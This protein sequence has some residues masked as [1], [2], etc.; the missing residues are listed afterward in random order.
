MAVSPGRIGATQAA[1]SRRLVRTSSTCRCQCCSIAQTGSRC[2]PGSPPCRACRTGYG[3]VLAGVDDHRRQIETHATA[4]SVTRGC[5]EIVFA[6]SADEPRE[7]GLRHS[8]SIQPPLTGAGGGSGTAYPILQGNR[9]LLLV[10]PLRPASS[11]APTRRTWSRPTP[12]YRSKGVRPE[13]WS[14][15]G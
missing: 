13:R 9:A 3:S 14:S 4:Q 11:T 8:M 1:V 12:S 5:G 7:R 15:P 2:G 6:D 10:S